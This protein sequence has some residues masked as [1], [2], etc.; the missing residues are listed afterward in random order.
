MANETKQNSGMN[1]TTVAGLIAF[2][3]GLLT[4]VLFIL[5]SDAL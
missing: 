2:G 3:L 4:V 5:F 1:R